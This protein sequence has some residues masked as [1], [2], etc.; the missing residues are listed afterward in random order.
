M[1]SVSINRKKLFELLGGPKAA[2]LTDDALAAHL[3][4]V[5]C[6]FEGTSDDKSEIMLE[7]TPDRPDLFSVYGVARA[8]K[9]RL[10]IEKG[11]PK[12][13]IGD[14]P[15]LQV[16]AEREA[17]AVRPVVVGAVI[18]GVNFSEDEIAK[19]FQL[20]EKL[21]LTLGRRRK[22]VSIG[23]YDL[24][25]LKPP[26]YFKALDARETSFTPLKADKPMTLRQILDAHPTGKEYAGLL[27]GKSKLPC[28]VDSTGEILSLIPVIN[29]VSS[30]VIP[31][32]TDFFIDHTGTDA[33]SC[34]AS[35]NILCQDFLDAGAQV[36]KVEV[37]YQDEA[38]NAQTGGRKTIT[39]DN[40]PLKMD[41]P[42]DK[43]NKAIGL[44]LDSKTA[45]SLLAKQRISAVEKPGAAGILQC[46]IPAF[47]SDFQHWIDLAE[48]LAVGLGY[49]KLEPLAPKSFTRGSLS[50][51]TIKEN[52]VRD[53]MAGAGFTELY[54]YAVTNEEKIE[55]AKSPEE[56]AEILNP[57]SDKYTAMR[58]TLLPNLL[59]VLSQN[60]HAPYPQKIFELGEVL[61]HNPALPEKLE[62]K[63]H[64]CVVSCHAQASLTETAS[65]LA[66]LC[67]RLKKKLSFSKLDSPQFIAGRAGQ[68]SLDATPKGAIGELHPQVL[69]NFGLQMPASAFEVEIDG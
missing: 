41:L 29:N 37:I 69:E 60:T 8:L 2:H 52:F 47:R 63:L 40:T 30:A 5:K 27:A 38:H 68:V 13:K 67:L 53:F 43:A 51:Q 31:A 28:L 54:T 57:V 10:E 39:P 64:L 19:V 9:G 21:D 15:A 17:L 14:K 11:L 44:K 23:L 24:R 3:E 66:E 61:V 55:R 58:A 33:H 42:L 25:T 62:T 48:E 56:N 7:A 6:G 12:N 26:F 65:I 4:Q 1:V 45:I 35:L 46:E 34:N 22:R 49:D 32:T 16:F 59:E 50:S 18:R 20:Q 36:E